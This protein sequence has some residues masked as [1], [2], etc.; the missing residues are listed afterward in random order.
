MNELEEIWR[1]V[2]PPTPLG[3]YWEESASSRSD[4]DDENGSNPQSEVS[5]S[6][7]A[8]L[9]VWLLPDLEHFHCSR[10]EG[11]GKEQGGGAPVE[12]GTGYLKRRRV[13]DPEGGR[14]PLGLGGFP[15]PAIR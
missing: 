7:T 2:H 4:E 1:E 12:G 14:D 9:A 8:T 5:V 6:A 15:F 11:E 13:C 3:E 10:R